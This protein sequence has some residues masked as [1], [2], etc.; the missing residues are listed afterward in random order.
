MTFDKDILPHLS[1]ISRLV[2]SFSS[3]PQLHLDHNQECL[4]QLWKQLPKFDPTRSHIKSW[5]YMICKCKIQ[6]LYRNKK[7]NP[8]TNLSFDLPSPLTPVPNLDLPPVSTNL[9][10]EMRLFL[11]GTKI[12]HIAQ[13]T[14]CAFVS[15]VKSR[16]RRERLNLK[17]EAECSTMMMP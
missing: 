9:S 1:Y 10:T 17:G 4:L 8:Q 16:L 5:I 3:N 7:P 14:D 12:K 6:D 13:L 15:T 2:R 11:R